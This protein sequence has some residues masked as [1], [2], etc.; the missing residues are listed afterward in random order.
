MTT[1][2]ITVTTAEGFEPSDEL[3]AALEQLANA[4][5]ESAQA[6]GGDVT[7]FGMPGLDLGITRQSVPQGEAFWGDGC[8]GFD[9][10]GDNPGCGWYK[11][12]G[13]SCVGFKFG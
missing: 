1:P 11:G 3:R 2:K 7:G 13:N 5:A 8:W 6:G 10:T 4:A 12:G 9:L